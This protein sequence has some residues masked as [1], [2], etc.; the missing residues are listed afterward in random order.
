MI[1]P[2]PALIVRPTT[3][4]DVAAS[5][6]FAREHGLPIAVR[7]GGHNVAGLATV[8]DGLVIDLA[9]MQSIDVDAQ[10]RTAR[11]GGGVTWGHLD[12]ATQPH[13]LATPGGV[14]SDTGIGGLTLGGGMG[15]LRRRH[16][17]SADNLT[18]AEVVLADGS[19]VWTSDTERP[20]LL[21]GLRGGGGNFGVVT[22]FEFRLHPL[23]PDVAFANVLYPLSDAHL[24]LRAHERIV[25]ANGDGTIST[26]AVLGHVPPLDV[27]EPALH[28]EPFVAVLAMYVGPADE[29]MAAL[30]PLREL[31]TPLVDFSGTVSYIEAQTVFDADYPAGHRYYWKSQRLPSLS[32]ASIDALVG[33]I[34]AAPSGHSTIDLWLNGGAM[35]AVAPDA[36]AFGPRDP[37]YLVSPEANWEDPQT[38]AENIAWARDVLASVDAEAA[39]GSYLNFPGMFE[40][41]STLVRTSFGP[42]YD[43]LAELKR[44]Y[45]PDNV[46][47]RN[48]NVAPA[49]TR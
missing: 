2:R 47:Q 23:G 9:L 22:T 21:W 45:D 28:G 8:D 40:E 30:Q 33:Q 12:A 5:I 13:G 49:A 46:F 31:A 18:G 17:L 35:S 19:I 39:G 34:E 14:V 32:D 36:T 43:R 24:V 41:G 1:D 29:G 20:D 3:A 15:W 7:G 6:G 25:A 4:A 38:D 37:G 10:T 11:A 48:Q 26:L 44:E 16:G 27:F 42:T